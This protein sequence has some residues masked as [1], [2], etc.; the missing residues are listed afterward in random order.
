MAALKTFTN[1]DSYGMFAPANPAGHKPAVCW[2]LNKVQ[3]GKFVRVMPGSGFTCAGA[4]Y[5]PAV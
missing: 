2:L 1:Y 3:G 4:S 5:Y